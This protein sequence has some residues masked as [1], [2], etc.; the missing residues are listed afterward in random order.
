MAKGIGIDV[1]FGFTK[2][3]S[4]SSNFI[5]PSLIGEAREIRFKSGYSEQDK[6]SNLDLQVDGDKYFIGEKAQRQSRHIINTL[7]KD[8]NVSNESDSL[9]FT[10]LGLLS[11]SRAAAFDLVTGLPVDEYTEFKDKLKTKLTGVHDFTLNGEN[12]KI[13]VK[14]CKVIPQPFGT[15]FN[16]LLTERGEIENKKLAALKIGVADIGFR[17]SDFAAADSME[18]IDRS[19]GSVNVGLSTAH[20][21]I[22]RVIND[23]FGINKKPLELE[24]EI[25]AGTIKVK[26]IEY[27]ITDTINQAFEL[28]AREIVSEM[29][30]IWPEKWSF[31]EIIITGGGGVALYDYISKQV[32]NCSLL[33][34]GQLAN[35]NGY[36]KLV[37]RTWG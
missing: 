35:A 24:E 30:N 12:K 36:L 21:E 20:R 23:R 10:A 22:A 13:M 34:N 3:V 11:D 16:Q 6:V 31:D 5:F 33:D 18:F 25:R 14:N 26:G 37:Q 4:K 27:D 29:N 8:R 28:T 7:D 15:L 32:D 17:T 19:S 2:A 9:F 1:G